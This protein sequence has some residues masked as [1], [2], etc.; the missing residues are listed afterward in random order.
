MKNVLKETTEAIK[1]FE[2]EVDEDSDGHKVAGSAS[3]K[4]RRCDR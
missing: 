2:E 1:H 4:V 3:D